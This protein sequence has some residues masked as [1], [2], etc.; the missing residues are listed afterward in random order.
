[1]FVEALAVVAQDYCNADTL[2]FLVRT[3]SR[4]DA[5]G[6]GNIDV[7]DVMHLI[8]YLFIQGSTPNPMTAGDANCD[9]VV[10]IADVMY[11]INYLFI[12]G[13]PPGC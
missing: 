3:Y 10:D 4:G 7:A 8:N 6:D 12:E 2:S 5:N 11:L 1:V 13:S 9:Q